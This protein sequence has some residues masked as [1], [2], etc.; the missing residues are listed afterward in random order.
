MSASSPWNANP[1]VREVTARKKTRQSAIEKRRAVIASWFT[2]ETDNE[3]EEDTA[4]DP[5]DEEEIFGETKVLSRLFPPVSSPRTEES[6]DLIRSINDPEH[7]HTLE[8][9]MVVSQ[10]QIRLRGNLLEVEFTPTVPHCG[11]AT[12]IGGTF[13]SANRE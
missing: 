5:I 8:S 10:K 11:M 3:G 9:L 6:I 12:I 13:W 2:L 7:P 4:E 1:V